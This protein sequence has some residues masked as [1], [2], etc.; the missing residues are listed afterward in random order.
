MECWYTNKKKKEKK[1]KKKEIKPN[2]N[3][4]VW[5]L[6]IFDGNT[7]ND[8]NVCKLFVLRKVIKRYNCLQRII[9]LKPCNYLKYLKSYNCVQIICIRLKYS[10]PYNRT[11]ING[12]YYWTRIV[13]WNHIIVYK[14]LVLKRVSWNYHCLQMITIISYEKQSMIA[15]KRLILELNIPTMVD[16]S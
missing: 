7:W 10:K 6:L 3:R 16:M 8:T 13:I 2:K 12:H 9:N 15:W 5:K 1:R 11:Q 14:V 4:S